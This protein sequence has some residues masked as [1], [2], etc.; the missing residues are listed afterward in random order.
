MSRGRATFR[1][2]DLK[3][4]LRACAA[5]GATMSIEISTDGT[6]R[7]VPAADSSHTPAPPPPAT[8][9]KCR[10]PARHT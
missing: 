3:R 6:I 5:V 7:L 8:M 1:E 4:A 10:N 9:I 2:S